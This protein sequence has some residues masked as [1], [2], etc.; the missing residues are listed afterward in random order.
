VY[1]PVSEYSDEEVLL[2]PRRHC[3]LLVNEII[4]TA[5]PAVDYTVDAP[6]FDESEAVAKSLQVRPIASIVVPVAAAAAHESGG[7]G[8]AMGV[9]VESN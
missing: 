8:V 5:A 2:D 1:S 9:G 6:L 3:R 4:V 7:D